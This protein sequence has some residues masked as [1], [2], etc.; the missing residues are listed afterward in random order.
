MSMEFIRKAYAVPCKR[1]GK[2]FTEGAAPK[3]EGQ[4]QAPRAPTS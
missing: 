3:S 1:G 4:S 2:S